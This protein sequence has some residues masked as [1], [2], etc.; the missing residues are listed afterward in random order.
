MVRQNAKQPGHLQHLLDLH[1]IADVPLQGTALASMLA[2]RLPGIL[3]ALNDE[4]ALEA[5]IAALEADLADNRIGNR[6]AYAGALFEGRSVTEAARRTR[7]AE[8]I[9]ALAG[10]ILARMT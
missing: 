4:E 5:E 8:E 9:E 2:A 6:N 3:P 7:A 1:D 10:E